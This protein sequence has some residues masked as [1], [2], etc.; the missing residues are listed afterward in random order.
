M[1]NKIVIVALLWTSIVNAD[2]NFGECLGSGT[3]EQQIHKYTN[4]E[5][6]VEVG[7]IPAGIKGLKIFLISDKDVDIRLYGE[8]ND[9]VVHW[10]KGILKASIKETKPYKNINVTYS[11]Y[12]G[13]NKEKGH[14]FI[15]VAGTTPTAM[16]MKAFGYNAGFATVN[17]SWTGKE[18]CI[19]K[20]GGTGNF[21]KTLEKSK[22]S[23][24]GTIP[25]SVNNVQINL[26]SDKDLDIQLY[27]VDGTA[28]VSWKPKGLL[29]AANKQNIL[30]ND[31]N[32]TWSGYNGTGKKQ[33]HEYIN[34]AGLTSEM[35]VMKVY[36]YEPGTANVTYSW[37]VKDTTAPVITLIGESN[38]TIEQY[39]YKTYY[40]FFGTEETESFDDK[41]GYVN[42][43]LSW[44]GSPSNIKIPG[45]YIRL[46]IAKDSAG[47]IAKKTRI[48]NIVL[49]PDKIAPTISLNGKQYPQLYVG[50]TYVELGA[51]AIDDRDGNVSVKITGMVDTTKVG[52]NTI[53]YMAQDSAGNM[54]YLKRVIKV[55]KPSV[56]SIKIAKKYPELKEGVEV[57]LTAIATYSDHS[58]KDI[59]MS[60][61]WR[62]KD[63]TIVSIVN[64]KLKALKEG[65][66]MIWV[67]AGA[68]HSDRF[69]CTVYKEINGYR[70]PLEPN[71][72]QNNATLLGIDSNDNGVR[73][74]VER[75]IIIKYQKPIEIELM[76]A[77]S[78]V[79]QEILESS[80]DKAQELQKKFS[81]VGDCEMYLFRMGI[82]IVDSVG[83]SENYTYNIKSRAKKY[84]EYNKALSGGVYGGSP[85]NYNSGACDF[86]VE[87]MLKD[88]K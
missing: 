58:S 87:Q 22:T 17:Y 10:P 59:S 33:G 19:P 41:D 32:I 38:I 36:G 57:N 49:P 34:I 78:K 2:F 35:L 7:K 48:I 51:T 26:T 69:S 66:T 28:I 45:K 79:T 70:L 62:I 20:N 3:F 46:Y 11:G 15:S 76:M 77:N 4:N 47:N 21:K 14:E 39:D 54:R 68:G 40:S 67:L 82:D 71:P 61:T 31:M 81:R 55:F 52:T 64:G 23:L 16:T 74:D 88:R 9:K 29:S 83:D 5:D 12:N 8:N 80:L 63:N 1:R 56:R 24:V 6:A 25:P 44:I 60:A 65:T 50:D 42:T 72:T 73:D 13:V 43:Q 53:T 37:G 27:G 84:M 18:G 85:L 30:Y 86:D 75:K